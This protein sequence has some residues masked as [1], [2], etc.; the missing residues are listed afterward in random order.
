MKERLDVLM[1]NRNLAESR[2]KAKAIIMSGNVFV[3]GQREDKAGSTFPAEA[4]IE[5]KGNPLKYVSRGGLKLE[6]AIESYQLSLEGKICMD[7]GSSTGGFTDC[8]LQNGAARVYAVDVGT[9]QLAWKLRQDPRVISM[10]KTNIRYL[11]PEELED[12]IAFASIDVSFISLTKVLLPVR[13]LL[14]AGGE[15]VCLIKPQF[16]A[17]RDKVGKKGVVRDRKVHEEVI[18]LVSSYAASIGF[19]CLALDFS[20]IK[21]PEGNIEYLLYLQKQGQVPGGLPCVQP[22]LSRREEEAGGK[23]SRLGSMVEEVVTEAHNTLS[24]G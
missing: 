7:V 24:I 3:D 17:G 16:E 13:E 9:N 6:K 19:L 18:R 12:V 15:V 4:S 10:E 11:T 20:P 5:V 21:G 23:L 22:E 14:A 8:M 2:E 1:V